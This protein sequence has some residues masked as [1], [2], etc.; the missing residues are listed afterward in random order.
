MLI[1]F[2]CSYELRVVI[3][4]TEDVPL[5]ES[6]ILTG[7]KCSDIFVKGLVALERFPNDRRKT[8][9]KP[10]TL[11]NHKER[12]ETITIRSN[13][14]KDAQSAGKIKRTWW[15]WFCFSLHG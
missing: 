6:N 11:T 12:D 8:K 1:L 13:Y 5:E 10:V 4:N 9:I 3:W 7:E 2:S 15:D 14:L